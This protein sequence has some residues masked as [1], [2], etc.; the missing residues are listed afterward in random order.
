MNESK[1]RG[2]K[3][4]TN[5]PKFTV[6]RD[7]REKKGKG[8]QFNKASDCNG[9][10]EQKMDTGDYTMLGYEHLVSIERK[11]SVLEWAQ[12]VSQDRFWRELERMS[13]FKYPFILLECDM[14]DIMAFPRYGVPARLKYVIRVQGSFILKRMNE[15]RL[16][17]PNIHILCVGKHGK[18]VVKSLFKRV[19]EEEGPNSE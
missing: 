9:T 17:Y 16:K 11:G 10:I 2:E 6:V 3:D 8:W 15:M 19:I 14:S 13:H 5:V 4:T 12:N 1:K 7:T 18:D